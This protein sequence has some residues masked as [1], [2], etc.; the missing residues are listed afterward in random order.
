MALCT[1]PPHLGIEIPEAGHG[2]NHRV[3]RLQNFALETIMFSPVTLNCGKI[4]TE[5][6]PRK[7][8]HLR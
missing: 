6:K 1:Q 7:G 8:H 5:Q 4:S 2:L 3:F